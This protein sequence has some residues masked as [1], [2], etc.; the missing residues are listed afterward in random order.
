MPIDIGDAILNFVINSAEGMAQLDAIGV[1]VP[2]KLAP[3]ETSLGG[4]GEAA[5]K[6]GTEGQNAGNSLADAFRLVPPAVQPSD[7]ALQNMAF[8]LRNLPVAAAGIEQVTTSLRGQT[9]QLK[10][11]EEALGIK[12]PRGVNRFLAELGLVG[13]VMEVAFAASAVFIIVEALVKFAE[14]IIE[15]TEHEEK[16]AAAWKKVDDDASAALAHTGDEILK[17]EAHLDELN[18]NH[19]GALQKTLT[20]LDHTTLAN[21]A[22]EIENIQ[23]DVDAAFDETKTWWD[24]I[25]TF[26]EGNAGVKEVKKDFDEVTKKY[27]D[28]LKSGDK[29]GAFSALQSGIDTAKDKLS[30]LIIEQQDYDKI[31]RKG[32]DE[33]G[34]L[35]RDAAAIGEKVDATNRLI[36]ALADYRAQQEASNKLE[37]DQAKVDR[38]EEQKK[39]LADIDAKEKTSLKERLAG[40]ET[41]KNLQHHAFND[42]KITAE[43]WS[44]AQ[45]KATL[46]ALK[47]ETDYD[48]QL[49]ANA[50]RE[51]DVGKGTVAARNAATDAT[52]KLNKAFEKAA[53]GLDKAQQETAKLRAEMEKLVFPAEK[54]KEQT[55]AFKELE[56][57]EKQLAQAQKTL[58]EAQ[59]SNDTK[60][61]EAAIRNLVNQRL[62][63]KRAEAAGLALIDQEEKDRALAVLQQTLDGELKE[64]EKAKAKFATASAEGITGEEL[65]KLKNQLDQAGAAVAKTQTEMLKLKTTTSD[66]ATAVAHSIQVGN[67]QLTQQLLENHAAL[68]AAEGQL[69]A[70]RAT[71]LNTQAMQTQIK[72]LETLVAHLK[73][74][75][76][77]LEG[78]AKKGLTAWKQF[79]AGLR[80]EAS[81]N[82]QSLEDMGQKMREQINASAQDLGDAFAAMMTGAESAG[83]AL[84]IAT[85]KAVASIAKMWAEYF[86][87]RAAADLMTPGEQ[88]KGAAELAASVA[89][90]AVAAALGSVGSGAGSTGSSA[91]SSAAVKATPATTAQAQP[92]QAVSVV[93]LADGGLVTSP[94]LAVVG[95]APGGEAV[96][97]L[98]DRAVLQELGSMIAAHINSA[99]GG[100]ELY[101]HI[102]TDYAAHVQQLN[103]GTRA[104]KWRLHS[105]TSDR[106]IKKT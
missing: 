53:D 83:K 91:S 84:E 32:G 59:V 44:A 47:A 30:K 102:S 39:A 89:L 20:L 88:A 94:T 26:G 97:P 93:H 10:V 37:Q 82:I 12:L 4:L 29:L 11:T 81:K 61:I 76:T 92:T 54:T 79:S 14:K 72:T 38:T 23:K 5:K 80:D 64:L 46:D 63:S 101:L 103:R 50:K 17:V 66:Y 106:A 57:A 95:D 90:Y 34:Q 71:G 2:A 33:S 45:I 55:Q 40:I 69:A 68:I 35:G 58:A 51:S 27:Q 6:V 70:A 28:L 62:I 22:K 85:A 8:S 100:G 60:E 98:R 87:A 13:P 77:Q 21:L 15:I 65:A 75:E 7:A 31:L 104:G 43:Q 19:L 25:T 67:L 74:E 105:T 24:Y 1:Q 3:A 41:E 9:E 73:Q 16:L 49:I 78:N 96:I 48:N 86:G 52:D 56:N 99:G 42:K 18:G 36:K